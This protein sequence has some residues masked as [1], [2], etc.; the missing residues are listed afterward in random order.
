[1]QEADEES[2]LKQ[3]KIYRILLTHVDTSDIK[4]V[5]PEKP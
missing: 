1:M 3:W 4:A 5:F 2:Q